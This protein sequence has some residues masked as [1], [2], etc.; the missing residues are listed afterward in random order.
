MIIFSQVFTLFII[1]PPFDCCSYRLTEKNQRRGFLCPLKRHV[2]QFVP[3]AK[4]NVRLN[5]SGILLAT[6]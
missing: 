3:F 1:A 6:C 4:S 5:K 2:R